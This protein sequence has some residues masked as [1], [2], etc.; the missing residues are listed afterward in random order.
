MPVNQYP[1]AIQIKTY[2]ALSP[3]LAAHRLSMEFDRILY[4]CKLLVR[5]H[6][7]LNNYYN[8]L[9]QI[10]LKSNTWI[11]QAWSRALR[12]RI[13]LENLDAVSSWANGTW[14]IWTTERRLASHLFWFWNLGVF[15]RLRTDLS[16]GAVAQ[17]RVVRRTDTL[18]QTFANEVVLVPRGWINHF[19]HFGLH[20]RFIHLKQQEW[21]SKNNFSLL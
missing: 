21:F 10:L 4:R 8:W 1:Q 15:G 9:P 6:C 18:L 19:L 16:N 13:Q 14:A 2:H 11:N 5:P 20:R 7:P 3:K 17:V 12:L